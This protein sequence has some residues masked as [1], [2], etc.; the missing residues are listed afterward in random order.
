MPWCLLLL[1]RLPVL[2][3]AAAAPLRCR[4][5]PALLPR[6]LLLLPFAR[7]CYSFLSWH[8]RRPRCLVCPCL[9]LLLLLCCLTGHSPEGL[10]GW[11]G[12]GFLLLHQAAAAA[13]EAPRQT[14]H[15]LPSAAAAAAAAAGACRLLLCCCCLPPQPHCF[16]C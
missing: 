4:L 5:L 12:M 10:Q 7:R 1:Q 13:G 11:Q 2:L 8:Q 6:L 3:L 9:L 16:H 15:H 14:A